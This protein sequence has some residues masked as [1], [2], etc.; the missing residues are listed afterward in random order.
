[1]DNK[2]TLC[3]KKY[4]VTSY[5]QDIYDEYNSLE[6]IHQTHICDIDRKLK[7]NLVKIKMVAKSIR[8]TDVNKKMIRKVAV[9]G[10]SGSFLINKAKLK[11]ADVFLTSDLK[12]HQFFDSEGELMLVDIGHYESEQFTKELLYELINKKFPKFAVRLSETNTNPIK[13]C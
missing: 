8:Y 12:Y 4:M 10:G 6:E 2:M 5:I 11:G 9:C 7:L 3:E 1:M 13:Y